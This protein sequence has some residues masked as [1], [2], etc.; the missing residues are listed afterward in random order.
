MRYSSGLISLTTAIFNA[1][2]TLYERTPSKSTENGLGPSQGSQSL[3]MIPRD[4]TRKAEGQ[5][6]RGRPARRRRPPDHRGAARGGHDE[7]GARREARRAA[8]PVRALRG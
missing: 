8:R 3:L 7:D 4:A 1:E 5:P 2:R 6:A